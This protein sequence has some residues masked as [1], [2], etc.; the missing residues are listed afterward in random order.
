VE[1]L[2]NA[3]KVQRVLE[4]LRAGKDRDVIASELGYKNYRSLDVFMRR[5][6]YSWDRRNLTYVPPGEKAS[7]AARDS[8]PLP[9]GKT[10]RVIAQFSIGKLDARGIAQKLG[11]ESH[12]DMAA[13]MESRGYY[14]DSELGNYVSQ[15]G[16]GHR[17]QPETQQ[18]EPTEAGAREGAAPPPA[19]SEA[20]GVEA[21]ALGKY[22]PLLEFL[23]E[24]EQDLREVLGEKPGRPADGSFPR[25][26][27]P[28]R[29]VT[30]SVYMSNQLD[31]LIRMFSEEKGI[32]Q[33][34]IFEIAL[35]D[36]FRKYGF[37]REIQSIMGRN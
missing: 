24:R 32:H 25:Y 34:E 21:G 27:I 33:R 36:F 6:G 16:N 9:P 37:E 18:P 8:G 31:E 11:F 30:K 19:A 28:G 17:Q 12:R 4:G 22:L 23:A 14:W 35:V 15:G 10:G 29:S 2:T 3:D 20:P 7:T 5:Q 13:Y 26:G 1:T